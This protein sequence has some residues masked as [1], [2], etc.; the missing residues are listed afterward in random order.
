MMI[1]ASHFSQST[2]LSTNPLK[3]HRRSTSP[4]DEMWLQYLV[5]VSIAPSMSS[6]E[7]L[8]LERFRPTFRRRSHNC[9]TY[10]QLNSTDW[11]GCLDTRRSLTGSCIFLGNSPVSWKTKK[12]ATMSK[13]T[14]KDEYRNLAS[15]VCELTWIGYLLQDLKDSFSTPIPLFCD[16][17][18]AI[19]ITANPVFHERTKH[20]EVNF[21]DK[22]K[23]GYVLPTHIVD[24]DQIAVVLTKPLSSPAF[25][26]LKPKLNLLTFS[27]SSTC[28]GC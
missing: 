22:F 17:K 21:R 3:L 24:K 28:G 26:S 1:P 14:T 2:T 4:A 23:S 15:T 20:L 10:A 6:L 8:D 18:A 7:V 19:D 11:A 12:Q 27:Q 25:L 16:N 13:F 5:Q 9:Q